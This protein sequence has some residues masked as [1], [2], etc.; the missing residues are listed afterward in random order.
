MEIYLAD[1]SRAAHQRANIPLNF[2]ESGKRGLILH[3]ED[4]V[5]SPKKSIGI[6][7]ITLPKKAL[8]TIS[9][10]RPLHLATD[11]N[12]DPIEIRRYGRTSLPRTPACSREHVENH[13]TAGIIRSPLV[14]AREFILKPKRK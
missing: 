10:D 9:R 13:I 3:H 12:A 1:K 7:S 14:Y 5:V 8:G 6:L 4:Q 2:F 11:G